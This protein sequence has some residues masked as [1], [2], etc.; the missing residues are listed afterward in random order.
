[1]TTAR[2]VTLVELLVTLGLV[3]VVAAVLAQL[4]SDARLVFMTQPQTADLVQ[5]GLE[6]L[7]VQ[8]PDRHARV[9][10]ILEQPVGAPR[11]GLQHGREVGLA[12][13]RQVVGACRSGRRAV[14]CHRS[15]VVLRYSTCGRPACTHS[16]S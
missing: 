8:A 3:L 9:G 7:Q 12:Q 10:R 2:G 11:V 6:D 1:M 5:R 13:R 16:R 14:A 15:S 4:A